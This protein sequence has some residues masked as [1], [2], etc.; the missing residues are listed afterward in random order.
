METTPC[1]P[2]LKIRGAGAVFFFLL[3]NGSFAETGSIERN[4]MGMSENGVYP[5]L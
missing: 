1:G 5:Q 4:N 3:S 2:E